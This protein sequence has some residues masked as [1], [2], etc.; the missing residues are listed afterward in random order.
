MENSCML[1]HV[2]GLEQTQE[3]SDLI[4]RHSD[5]SDNYFKI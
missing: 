3:Q 4:K 2:K 1:S 5:D